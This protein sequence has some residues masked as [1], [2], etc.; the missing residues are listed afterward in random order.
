MG[1]FLCR[2]MGYLENK[3]VGKQGSYTRDIQ[4]AGLFP[5]SRGPGGCYSGLVVEKL[6]S[7]DIDGLL[8]RSGNPESHQ[9][10]GIG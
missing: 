1:I 9:R 8:E 10:F 6:R 5:L 2:V 4:F 7:L 3:K